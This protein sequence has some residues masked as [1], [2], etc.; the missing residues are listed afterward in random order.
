MP[1]AAEVR[2]ITDKLRSR[3]KGR[4]LLF[5]T[6]TQHNR[7]TA[8]LE[9]VWPQIESKFPSTCLDILCK[10]KQLFFF[11]EN[12]LAFIGGLGMEGHWY[13]FKAGSLEYQSGINYKM[14]CLHFGKQVIR[15]GITWYIGDT[16]LWYDDQRSF[17]NFKVGTWADAFSKMNELGPD[18]L[19]TT[20]PLTDINMVISG[21]LPESFRE[22]P[23]LEMFQ[24]KIRAPRR[25]GMELCRFLMNQEYFSGVG[26]YLKAEILYR[27]RLHPARTLGSLTDE[28]IFRLFPACLQTIAQAYEHGGLTHGTFLDPDREKGTFPVAVYKREGHTDVHGYAIKRIETSDKRSTYIVE[29][30]QKI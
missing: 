7:H 23:T 6:W 17:G 30:L 8:Y 12:G 26:N 24:Q 1:E 15:R 28:E 21:L 11:L 5:L 13:Y 18:M 20:Y 4:S 22:R 19:A 10:G 14:F 25:S 3:L 9:Q 2:R 16:E 27:A 29:E